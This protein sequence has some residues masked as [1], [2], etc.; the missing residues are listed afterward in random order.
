MQTVEEGRQE[1]V[2][3]L[4]EAI[5]LI[6][7]REEPVMQDDTPVPC[8]D[9]LTDQS[10]DER[11]SIDYR[12]RIQPGTGFETADAV[13]R[14]L[15]E[16]GWSISENDGAP[17]DVRMF[18]AHKD[19]FSLLISTASHGGAFVIGGSSPCYPPTAEE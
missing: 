11:A 18:S 17:E 2:A 15:E 9:D 5:A 14:A 1:L 7:V 4:E 3:R 16:K 13:E 19:G 6:D 10:A 8:S 12:I